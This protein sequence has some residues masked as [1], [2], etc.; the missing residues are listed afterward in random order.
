MN[1]ELGPA[2]IRAAVRWF[3]LHLKDIAVPSGSIWSVLLYQAGTFL[4]NFWPWLLV[5]LRLAILS[6]YT[7]D[8]HRSSRWVFCQQ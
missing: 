6:S 2:M 8:K 1:E 3:D 5:T 7:I 4:M